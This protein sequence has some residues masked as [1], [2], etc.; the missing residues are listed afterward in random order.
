MER[1]VAFYAGEFP[2]SGKGKRCQKGKGVRKNL[3][4]RRSISPELLGG[5]A[6]VILEDQTDVLESGIEIVADPPERF[7]DEGGEKTMSGGAAA[8]DFQRNKPI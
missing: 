8:G 4:K 1:V 7:A 6:D 2:Q 5:M 3:E